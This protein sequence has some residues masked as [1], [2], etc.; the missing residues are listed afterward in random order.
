MVQVFLW[1]SLALGSDVWK[2]LL[3]GLAGVWVHCRALLCHG[4]DVAQ[5]FPPVSWGTLAL[6]SAL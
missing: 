6:Q 1:V 5:R 2:G 4:S 3:W